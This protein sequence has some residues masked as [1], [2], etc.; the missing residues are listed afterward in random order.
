MVCDDMYIATFESPF[1]GVTCDCGIVL[2]G[3]CMCC[4]MPSAFVIEA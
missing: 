3:S 4:V 2:V 1:E